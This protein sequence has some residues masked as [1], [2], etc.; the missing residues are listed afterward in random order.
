MITIGY[1]FMGKNH[2]FVEKYDKKWRKLELFF[3]MFCSFSV[4]FSVFSLVSLPIMT[5]LLF[6]EH[7]DTLLGM[8]KPE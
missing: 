5:C 1:S 3:F 6:C 7:L 8:R 4:F 2:F